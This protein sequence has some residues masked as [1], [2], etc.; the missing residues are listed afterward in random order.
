GFDGLVTR[1][2]YDPYS[3]RLASTQVGQR[4][5]DL[6][7]DRMNRLVERTARLGDQSQTETFAY[8]GNGKLIQAIN[9]VSKLQW[10]HDE[11]GN[12]TR[13]HQHYLAT[14]TPM[15]AVWQ[16]TYDALNQR[17]STLRP[18]GHK[19]SWLTYGS[20]HLLGMTLD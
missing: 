10:F 5:I 13:E 14:G 9:A 19:V 15:V 3:G 20:G 16:H 2:Q 8:D 17:I 7:F 11:A 6:R 1:Y 18:D 4:R 12:L